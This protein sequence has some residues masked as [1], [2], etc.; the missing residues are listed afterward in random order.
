MYLRRQF[1]ERVGRTSEIPQGFKPSLA[2]KCN[3]YDQ[4]GEAFLD[5][6]SG[7]CVNNIGHSH[8]KVIEAIR[9]QAGMYLHTNVYAEHNQSIQVQLAE[10]LCDQLP[11][12]FNSIYFLNS[13]SEV[14]DASIKLARKVTARTDIV[15]CKNSYHGSTLGAESLRS[16][17]IE[18]S[19]FRP[20][21][22]GINFIASNDF[23]SLNIIN[24]NT[25]AVIIEV[26]QAE[27]GVVNLSAEF[28]IA[29][30]KKC[31]DLKC[32]L[33]FD[34]I[35]TGF[36]RTGTLFAFQKHNVVPDLLLIGKAF[37]AGLPLSGIVGSKELIHSFSY[38]PSLGY[39]ST[40]GGNPLCCAA[41]L[42]GLKVL[43]EEKLIERCQNASQLF[44]KLLNH[45][46][47]KNIRAEGLLIAVDFEDSNLVWSIINSLFQNKMLA[48]SFLFNSG[49]LRIAPPLV[50]NDEEIMKA[51]TVINNF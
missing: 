4:N 7:F 43:L 18:R 22:P 23:E 12:G 51:T 27:A 1:L 31:N 40:F 2:E 9:Q 37:G 42:A 11:S 29:I 38:S 34:E 13:G 19:A 32:L 48:E 50:I 16:D 45:P 39:I 30:R 49:S 14:I 41:A 21:I 28:L 8:P 3:I 46:K 10:Y 35:Q 26:V 25:A 44:K 15:A 47:I 33:I 20:L 36:G 17:S 6:I 5:L 24:Q